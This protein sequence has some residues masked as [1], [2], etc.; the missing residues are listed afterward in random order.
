[1]KKQAD[2]DYKAAKAKCKPLKGAEEKAC[3]KD[4]KAAHEKAEADIKRFVRDL[5][6]EDIHAANPCIDETAGGWSIPM[7]PGDTYNGSRRR[8]E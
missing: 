4:A 7:P 3:K 8:R 6:I 2:G 5:R 1:M